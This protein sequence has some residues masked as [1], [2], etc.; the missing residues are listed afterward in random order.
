MRNLLK[1]SQT[2]LSD[3]CNNKYYRV[4]SRAKLNEQKTASL[5]LSELQHYKRPVTERKYKYQKIDKTLAIILKL[6]K[7]TPNRK[8]A[9]FLKLTDLKT[10]QSTYAI[11]YIIHANTFLSNIKVVVTKTNGEPLISLSAGTQLYK[12]KQK[13]NKIAFNEMLR[14]LIVNSRYLKKTAVFLVA[15]TGIKRHRTALLARLKDVYSVKMVKV[16]NL[17]PHNGCRARKLKRK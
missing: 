8:L 10:K 16:N 3:V 11:S 4:V 5:L 6:K 2:T 12:G 17:I 13:M 14:R 15:L 1:L 9:S 7:T